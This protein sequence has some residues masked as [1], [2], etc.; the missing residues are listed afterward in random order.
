MNQVTVAADRV[1][2]GKSLEH[3]PLK[4]TELM[5]D[6]ESRTRAVAKY[7]FRHGVFTDHFRRHESLGV[8]ISFEHCTFQAD[9]LFQ[10]ESAG[11]VML[12]GVS[13]LHCTL[14]EGI[15]L[16]FCDIDKTFSLHA[17]KI[18]G[19]VVIEQCGFQ[20][21]SIPR[22]TR[23]EYGGGLQWIEGQLS[24]SYFNPR[25]IRLNNCVLAGH[26]DFEVTCLRLIRCHVP[27]SGTIV[28]APTTPHFQLMLSQCVVD[29]HVLLSRGVLY[30][31]DDVKRQL[32]VRLDLSQSTI[33]GEIDASNVAVTWVHLQDTNLS[34]GSFRLPLD[35]LRNRRSERLPQFLSV[36]RA[37]AVL[38]ELHYR[39]FKL[40]DDAELPSNLTDPYDGDE[41]YL[42]SRRLLRISQEY[43]ELRDSF[44]HTSGA[45][46]QEDFCHYKCRE[47]WRLYELEKIG[48]RRC[49]IERVLFSMSI[50]L[51]ILWLFWL[52]GWCFVLP[53][54][55]CSIAWCVDHV[56]KANHPSAFRAVIWSLGL[57]WITGHGAS[58]GRSLISSAVAIVLYAVIV[59]SMTTWSPETGRVVQTGSLGQPLTIFQEEQSA[60]VLLRSAVQYSVGG[61]T[62][63]DR[64]REFS[65]TTVDLDF[66]ARAGRCLYFSTVTFTTLGYG[67]YRPEGRLRYV[68]ASEAVTGAI[69]IALITVLLA[70]RFLRL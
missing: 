45:D 14:C 49:R 70:R 41:Y 36:D 18:S 59:F 35:G 29:G 66:G 68:A 50:L 3:V 44:I 6:L 61:L 67:D 53:V 60:P 46:A 23:C 22:I 11:R 55:P 34:S 48:H 15:A 47:Y 69:M 42:P 8:A 13:F 19:N 62:Q 38:Q 31:M 40:S 2:N 52:P 57:K 51:L 26:N 39:G 12:L 30:G 7:V 32:S 28:V 4:L 24:D 16:R 33:S 17:T 25:E 63:P 64:I 27:S 10:G 43:E 56:R 21:G 37:G 1:L 9:L 5:A 58:F 20:T 65:V 54:L